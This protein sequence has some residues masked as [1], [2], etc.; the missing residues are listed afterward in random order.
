MCSVVVV[1]RPTAQPRDPASA[2]AVVHRRFSTTWRASS[3]RSETFVGA[4]GT[5]A[6]ARGS[7]L[8]MSRRRGRV[9]DLVGGIRWPEENVVRFVVR[10]S[11]LAVG[12]LVAQG[13]AAQTPPPPPSG[14][15]ATSPAA[16]SNLVLVHL[17]TPSDVDLEQDFGGGH[18]RVVCESPCDRPLETNRQYRINGLG[19]ARRTRS[20]S[21]PVKR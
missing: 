12:L 10:A 13:A 16:A 18:W 1:S 4:G 15:T 5:A 9:P 7:R 21:A 17:D 6:Y 19:C 8:A 14:V 20:R 11:S 3:G 2:F